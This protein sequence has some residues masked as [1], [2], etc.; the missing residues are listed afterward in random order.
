VGA[1]AYERTHP[2]RVGKIAKLFPEIQILMVHMGGVSFQD[3]SNSAIEVAQENKNINLV[4]SAIRSIPILKAIKTLGA[5]RV[6]FGSDTPFELMHVEVA[7]YKAML[8]GFV[9]KEEKEQIMSFN[10]AKILKIEN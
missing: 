4:G 6:C 1:D 2:F 5:S 9:T 8:E 3:L 7:K 10:I